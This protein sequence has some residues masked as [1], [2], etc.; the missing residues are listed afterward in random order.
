[1]TQ[2]VLIVDDDAGMRE[3]LRFKLG[4]ND[5]EVATSS[6][7]RECLD[8]L[9]A[10]PLPDLVLLDI[11]MPYMDGHEVLDRIR[12]EIDAA[13]PVVL[14]TAAESREEIDDGIEV[15][16]HIE[17]PFRMNEVVDCVE[18]VLDGSLASD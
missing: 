18:H 5:F 2:T 9:E 11:M 3:L 1:M 14:L 6:N 7:G 15:S 16:D 12:D 4:K 8:Y 17:K 13:L 10:E